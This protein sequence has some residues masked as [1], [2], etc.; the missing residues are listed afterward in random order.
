MG[1]FSLSL[2]KICKM[3]LWFLNKRC[4]LVS[5]NKLG[6]PPEHYNTLY[7]RWKHTMGGQKCCHIVLFSKDFYVWTSTM[8]I[9]QH[10]FPNCLHNMIDYNIKN[11]ITKKIPFPTYIV[12]FQNIFVAK[13]CTSLCTRK[14]KYTQNKI[15]MIFSFYEICSIYQT[16]WFHMIGISLCVMWKFW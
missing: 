10:I 16:L 5:P 2:L 13:K 4:T 7:S 1:G 11:S 14:C 12:R 3:G 6:I 8:V 9:L 15:E